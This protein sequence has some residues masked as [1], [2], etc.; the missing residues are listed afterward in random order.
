MSQNSYRNIVSIEIKGGR[1]FSN[2]HNRLG[3]A[4]KS[5]QKAKNLGYVECWTIVNVD[6]IDFNKAREESPSTNRFYRISK[7]ESGKG[8]EFEDFRNRIISLTGIPCK[9]S[10]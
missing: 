7:L 3:E 10:G 5:H 2:I 8:K 9:I 4:E 6:N 1:D